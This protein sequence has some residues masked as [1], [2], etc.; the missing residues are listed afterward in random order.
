MKDIAPVLPVGAI[1]HLVGIPDEGRE[2]MLEWAAAAFNAIG[3]TPD[4]DDAA[5]LREAFAFISSMD[6]N[7]VAEGSWSAGLFAA[8]TREKRSEER[9]VGNGGVRTCKSW[10]LALN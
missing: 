7:K 10:C 2:R 9:G 6:E 8:R 1:S 3:P 5:L 4:A